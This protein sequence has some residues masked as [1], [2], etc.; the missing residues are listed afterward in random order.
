M[1]KQHPCIKTLRQHNKWRR[2]EPGEML[3]PSEIGVALDWAIKVCE[4]ADNLV[5]VKGRH[6]AEQAYKRLDAAVNPSDSE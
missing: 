4:A 2:G 1:S 6:H 5:N 3:D